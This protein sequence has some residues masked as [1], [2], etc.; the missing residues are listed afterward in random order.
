M[1]CTKCDAY[2]LCNAVGG[3]TFCLIIRCSNKNKK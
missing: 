1:D 3:E 2:D